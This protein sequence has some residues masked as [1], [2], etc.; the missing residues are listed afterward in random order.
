MRKYLLGLCIF[1]TG[2][3]ATLVHRPAPSDP[4]VMQE[5]ARASGV[6]HTQELY[7]TL[8]SYYR[9]DSARVVI[10][11]EPAI[12]LAD[13]TVSQ[14][15]IYVHYKGAYLPVGLIRAWGKL[16]QAQFLTSCPSRHIVQPAEGVAGTFELEV[17]GGVCQ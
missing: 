2:C 11:T 9:G 12:K 7:F 4:I 3:S 16:A 8:I 1:L 17:T 6:L 13:L 10:L 14:K 15:Q 5:A